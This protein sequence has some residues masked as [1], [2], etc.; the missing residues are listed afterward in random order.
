MGVDC[1]VGEKM[2]SK[3]RSKKEVPVADAGPRSSLRSGEELSN[4]GSALVEREY[5]KKEKGVCGTVRVLRGSV[6]LDGTRESA[7][8]G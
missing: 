2:L 1:L 6:G 5:W 3:V 7:L 8:G 4:V